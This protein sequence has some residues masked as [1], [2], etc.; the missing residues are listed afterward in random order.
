[1][2]IAI[3][4]LLCAALFYTC[5]CRLVRTSRDTERGVRLAFCVLASAA[6]FC[7]AAPFIPWLAYKPQGPTLVIEGA[8]ALVQAI[9]AR[10]WRDGVPCHFQKPPVLAAATWPDTIAA[11][12]QCEE[13]P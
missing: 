1:M 9:T 8:M 3:N 11:Q 2:M 7:L 13:H 10:Y 6:A 12:D 5:F 4:T